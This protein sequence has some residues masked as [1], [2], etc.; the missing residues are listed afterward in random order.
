M[1]HWVVISVEKNRAGIG[2]V[3][4]EYALD[5]AHFRIAPAGDFVRERLIDEKVTLE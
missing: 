1:R 3:D 2:A 4:A 5:A